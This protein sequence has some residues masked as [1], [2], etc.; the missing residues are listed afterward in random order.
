MRSTTRSPQR[1]RFAP[2]VPISRVHLVTCGVGAE[3]AVREE[4]SAVF[5]TGS[6]P[7][8]GFTQ[9]EHRS[10]EHRVIVRMAKR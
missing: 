9:C 2:F 8:G 5:I 1:R 4:S 10:L 7:S 6:R 3:G